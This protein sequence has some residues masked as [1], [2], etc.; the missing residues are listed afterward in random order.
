MSETS[1]QRH[2]HDA[3]VS[4]PHGHQPKLYNAARPKAAVCH[5]HTVLGVCMHIRASALENTIGDHGICLPQR[6]RR[7]T[8]R[9]Q[10]R[11]ATQ[12]PARYKRSAGQGCAHPP[13]TR[14][15]ASPGRRANAAPARPQRIPSRPLAHALG[16]GPQKGSPNQPQ[17]LGLELRNPTV[18]KRAMP[19]G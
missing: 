19:R 12:V 15:L 10:A 16:L 18:T 11:L 6:E 13:T 9:V 17:A 4:P 14:T 1:G 7:C 5:S 8:A 3:A 2:R